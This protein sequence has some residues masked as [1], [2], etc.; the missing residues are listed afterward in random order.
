IAEPY[1]EFLEEDDAFFTFGWILKRSK[2]SCIFLRDGKCSIYENRPDLCRTY[3]FMIAEDELIVSECI[4]IGSEI[5][6]RKAERL[7]L[8]LLR[9]REKEKMDEK[10][11]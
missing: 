11:R 3:P 5:P 6:P 8:A 10:M 4:G 2:E 1:P 9:R 7:A